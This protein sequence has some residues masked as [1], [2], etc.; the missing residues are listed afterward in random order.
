[1]NDDRLTTAV[2]DQMI[3]ARRKALADKL[4]DTLPDT[5]EMD[6]R[7]LPAGYIADCI[8]DIRALSDMRTI[9][10]HREQAERDAA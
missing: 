10:A 2:L 8:A 6:R 1:M 9:A 5:P 3:E 7:H 4:I